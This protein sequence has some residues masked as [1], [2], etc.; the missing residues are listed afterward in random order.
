MFV[1]VLNEIKGNDRKLKECKRCFIPLQAR[2]MLHASTSTTKL[3]WHFLPHSRRILMTVC[4]WQGIKILKQNGNDE[5]DCWLVCVDGKLSGLNFWD[6]PFVPFFVEMR[7]DYFIIDS[8]LTNYRKVL[9]LI[10][11]YLSN[12]ELISFFALFISQNGTQSQMLYNT[13]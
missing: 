1:S 11:Y 6:R 4:H 9:L 3:K 10:N 2:P 13:W 5:C 7:N 8:H 12:V